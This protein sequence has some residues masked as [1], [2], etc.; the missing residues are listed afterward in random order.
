MF[1]IFLCGIHWAIIESQNIVYVIFS[2]EIKIFVS[3][4]GTYVKPLCVGKDLWPCGSMANILTHFRPK[5]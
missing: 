4:R 1:N 5:Y 3:I 2:H